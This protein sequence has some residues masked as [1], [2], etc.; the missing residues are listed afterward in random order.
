M[1][2]VFPTYALA[3]GAM[4]PGQVVLPLAPCGFVLVA[5]AP[6]APSN[7]VRLPARGTSPRLA[8]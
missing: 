7:V 5:S 1:S 8:A 2:I 6:R 4:R 3:L